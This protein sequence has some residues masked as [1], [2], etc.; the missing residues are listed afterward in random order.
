MTASTSDWFLLNVHALLRVLAASMSTFLVLAALLLVCVRQQFS[1]HD[2]TARGSLDSLELTLVKCH[3]RA[4]R[5]LSLAGIG[6]QLALVSLLHGRDDNSAG[7]D[8]PLLFSL[9]RPVATTCVYFVGFMT[10]T[11]G[12]FRALLLALLSAVIAS[13][14]VAEVQVAMMLDC[15]STQNLQCGSSGHLFDNVAELQT[16]QLRDLA[17]LFVTPWLLLEVGYLCVAVGVCTSRFSRRQLSL[18]RPRFN[19]RAGLALHFP[20]EFGAL[21]AASRRHRVGSSRTRVRAFDP[22]AA[23]A[24]ATTKDV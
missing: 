20:H 6:L 12:A 19:V 10:N 24:A 13:D 16:L 17:S 8:A 23:T 1:A 18:S 2:A 15:R 11:H 4:A 21:A 22:S 3:T 14:V 9:V 7:K 5:L